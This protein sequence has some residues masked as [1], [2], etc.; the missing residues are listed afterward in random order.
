M[1]DNLKLRRLHIE[2]FQSIKEIDFEYEERG[3]NYYQGDNNIGKSSI[4][5]AINTLFFNASNQVYRSFIRDDE[6]SFY[7]SMT[8]FDGNTVELSRGKVDFYRWN[9]D[10]VE[11]EFNRTSGKV[12]EEVREYFSL[13]YDEKSKECVNIRLPRAVLLGVDTSFSDNNYLLQKALKSEVYTLA[14]KKADSLKKSHKKE[15]DVLTKYYEEVKESVDAI[16]LE[17]DR[18]TLEEVERY[19]RTLKSEYDKL[20]SYTHLQELIEDT[21]KT[22]RELKELDYVIDESQGIELEFEY[23][24]D[25]ESVVLKLDEKDKLTKE[26]DSLT[27]VLEDVTQETDNIGHEIEYLD[28]LNECLEYLENYMKLKKD[29]K[30]IDEVLDSETEISDSMDYYSDLNTHLSNTETKDREEKL[31]VTLN[32]ELEELNREIVNLETEMGVCPLCG[33]EFNEEHSHAK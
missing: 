28:K 11:G 15:I 33:N 24:K 18:N 17:E 1:G 25:L 13:Y 10:G 4:I 26:V 7:I 9:I 29:I 31:L 21:L 2:N 16:D 32:E 23:Y 12:P 5:K 19:E 30:Q 27:I 8:D 22:R 6:E 3:V 20:L 14:Y